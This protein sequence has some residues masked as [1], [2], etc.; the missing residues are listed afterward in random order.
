MSIPIRNLYYLMLYAWDQFTPGA[1]ADVGNDVSPDLP[2]LLSKVL[3]RGSNRLIRRGL[4]RGYVS[5]TDDTK[6]PRG[7]LR[8]DLM[9]KRQTMLKGFAAC[10]LD[11]FTPNILHNQIL[12]ETLRA[13]ASCMDVKKSTRHDL[14]RTYNKLRGVDPIRLSATVFS[15]VKLSKNSAHYLSLIK[16]CELVFHSM[17]PDEL[18]S[19]SKFNRISED[20]IRMS[21]LFEA[22]LLNFYRMEANVFS[23]RSETLKWDSSTLNTDDFAYLPN[24]C[25]DITLFGQGP[26]S[27]QIIVADAKYYKKALTSGRFN[28]ETV[29]SAH[30]YQLS[31]YIAHYKVKYPNKDI[32]GLLIYPSNKKRLRLSYELLGTPV[33]IVTV[34]LNAPWQD[35]HNEVLSLLDMHVSHQMSEQ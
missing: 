35:I 18:G 30:L 24:M 1:I 8:L 12:K 20:D 26:K 16:I 11:E 4:D 9:T 23:A 7:K 21:A 17:M 5:H 28:K 14:L 34:N 2:N 29:R 31:T 6:F 19:G 22:F 13:L 33:S 15:D 32:S 10:D 27:N 25:T 3:L